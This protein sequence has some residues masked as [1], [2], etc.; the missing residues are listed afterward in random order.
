MGGEMEGTH[1][2]SRKAG[3][4][5]RNLHGNTTRISTHVA[6]RNHLQ[7]TYTQLNSTQL[8]LEKK[9]RALS[10]D[11]QGQRKRST[12]SQVSY[13]N[14]IYVSEFEVNFKSRKFAG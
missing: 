8:A 12:V 3:R 6:K 2:T 1:N 10:P 11:T 4:G 14:V 5:F 9:T 7:N 13:V